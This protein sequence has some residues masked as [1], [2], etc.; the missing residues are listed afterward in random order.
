MAGITQ[1]TMYG[2]RREV[3]EKL[4]RLPL[5]YFDSHPHGDILSQVTNDIDNLTTTLQQGL[6]QLLTSVLTIA[7]VMG[8][9][10]KAGARGSSSGQMVTRHDARA[11]ATRGSRLLSGGRRVLCL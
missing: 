5:R 7:G 8:M 1:R 9:R 10:T 4:A 6:S 11:A 2:L 3:E